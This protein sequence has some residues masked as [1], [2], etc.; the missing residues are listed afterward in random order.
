MKK[1]LLLFITLWCAMVSIAQTFDVEKNAALQIVSANRN[2]IGL[3]ADDLNNLMVTYSYVDKTIGVRYIYLQQTYQGIPVYNKTQAIAYKNDALASVMG[4][5][6]AN[7]ENKVNNPSGMPSKTAES[8]V[9]AALA[10]KGFS[11]SGSLV[12]ISTKEMGRKVEFG[13]LGVSKQNVTAQLMW[14]PSDNESSLKLGWFVYYIPTTTSD[15]WEIFIDAANSSIIGENNLT[16]SCNWDDPNHTHVFGEKHNEATMGSNPFDFSRVARIENG[17]TSPST[18]ANASYRVIPVPFEAPTFMPGAFPGASPGNSTV[19]NNPWTNVPGSFAN[20]VTLNWHSDAAASDYAYTRGNNVWAYQDRGNANAPS[21]AASASSTTALPALTFSA[22]GNAP[23]YTADPVTGGG[24]TGGVANNQLFNITNLFYFNN[25]LHDV[26]YTH[27]FDEVARN[28]QANNLGRGGNGNDYVFAEAQDGSGTNNANMSTP[29]D[30]GNGRMQMYLW[31]L[32][33]PQRDGDVDNGIIGHEFGHGVSERLM[34]SSTNQT[35]CANGNVGERQGEGI[36]DYIGLMFTQDWANSNVNSGLVGRGI[37]TFALNQPVTGVGIRTQRYSTDLAINNKKYLAVLPQTGSPHERGEHWCAAAWEATWA[38]IQ[39][40]GTISPTIY[41]NSAAGGNGNTG[42]IAAM[43]IAMQAMKLIPCGGGFIDH[44]NAWLKADTLLYGG[45]F[46]CSIWRAFQKRGMGF[47]ADQ[48]LA[49]SSTDQTP[50]ETAYSASNITTGVAT[51]PAGQNMTYTVTGSTCSGTA[52]AGYEMRSTLPA[53]V[54]FVSATNGGVLVGNI[55]KWPVSMAANGTFTAQVTITVNSNAF[56]GNVVTTNCLFESNL[57]AAR[58]FGCK[59]VTTPIT[60]IL[61]GCPTISTQPA[62]LTTCAG[63]SVNFSV[64]ANAVNTITYKWQLLVGATWTDLT[65]IAPYSNVGTATMTVNPT[66]VGL[67]GNQYRCLMTTSD[68]TGGIT[69]N[70]ATLTVVAASVGGAINPP[71]TTVCGPTSSTLMTLSGHVGNVVRWEVS[72]NGGGTWSTIAGTAGATTYTAINVTVTSQYRAVVQVSGGCAAVNSAIAVITS[73]SSLPL[74]IQADPATPIC[75]GDPARLTAGEGGFTTFSSATSITI[76]SSGAA[77]PYPSNLAVSGLPAGTTVKS[78]TLRGMNHTF[79]ADIDVVLRSPGGINVVLMSDIGG[80]GD[81]VNNTYTFDDAAT[82]S[83]DASTNPP[84]NGTYKPSNVGAT[85][86]MPAPFPG[87]TITQAAPALSLFNPGVLNGT[88]ELYVADDLGGD[89]GDISGGYQIV[90]AQPFTPVTTGTFLWTPATGLNS[91][92][93]NPVAASPNTTTTYTVTHN[94][95]V[96]CTRQASITV[97]VNQRPLV[98]TQPTSVV[99]CSGS[100]ATFSITATGTGPLTYQ[101]QVG[102]SATGPWTNIVAGAPYSGET[103]ATLTINPTSALLNNNWYRCTVGGL[104]APVAGSTSQPAK[105]SVN[106]LP[107]VAINPVGPVCGGIK[108]IVGTQLSVASAAPPVPGSQTFTSGI[109]NVLIPEGA[110]PTRP[111]TA[112]TNVIAVAGIPANATITSVAARLNA[113]HGFVNDIVAVLKAPTGAVIN[114]DAIGGYANNAGANYVNT[115]FSTAGVN[116]IAGGTAPFSNTYKM[117]AAG[118]TFSAFGFTLSGGPVG[119]DPTTTN[120]ALFASN[121]TGTTANGN[122]TLAAYDAGAPDV[123]NFTKWDLIINYTTPGTLPGTQ[124]W[125]Y[126]WAPTTGLYT[127]STASNQ[128]TGGNTQTVYAAPTA[129]TIYTVS[130][131]DTVTGCIGTS[132]VI[133]NYTP[134]AP[135]VTPNPVPMCLGDVP[136][137]VK[138]SS[139]T[140]TVANFT[141]NTISVAIPEGSFPGRPATAGT[142]A[143]AVSGIPA[144]ATITGVAVTLNATHAFVNDIVAV[145]KSPSGAV[146]NLDAIGGYQNNA[147]ANYLNTVFS[148][149]GTAS[150]STGTAP[151]TGTWKADL[152]GVTFSAFGFTLFGGPT[153]YDPTTTNWA[154]YMGS[155]SATP[156]GNWTIATYDVGAPDVGTLTKWDLKITYVVGVPATPAVWTPNGVGSGLY[157]NAAGTTPY[158]GTP[159]DS[160]WVRP[161]PAGTYNYDVTVQSLSPP[162][163]L[164]ATPMAGGNGNNTV[165]FNVTNNNGYAM[166]LTRISSNA[167][168]SGGI[169]AN[170]FFKVSAIAGNPGQISAANGWTL[171]G[172]SNQASTVTANTL[173]PVLTALT[174]ITIPAGATYGIALEFAGATVPAYTNGTGTV[175]TFSNNGCTISVDGN[176]GWGG[177]ATPGPMVNNPRNFNGT[178]TLVPSNAAPA[179]TSPARKLVVNVY[180]PVNIT[181]QPVPASVCTDKVTTFTATATGSS[182]GHN[183]QISA[184]ISGNAPWTNLVNNTIYSGVKT[185]TLTITNPPLSLNRFIYRDSVT[186]SSPCGPVLS[187]QAALT[188]NPLPTV[189]IFAT[190]HTKLFPGLS[191]VLVDTTSRPNSTYIWKKNGTVVNGSGNKI[192]VNVDGM[193]DYALTVTDGNGCTASSNIVTISDSANGKVFIYPNPNSGVFQVRY[194]APFN[195]RAPRGLNIYD[196]KGSRIAVE[197][198]P[199][200]AAYQRMDVDLRKHGKG[201]YWVEVID[202]NGE[203]LAVGRAVVL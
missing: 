17:T 55:V 147:G 105:L 112:A 54:T 13:K 83:M 119:F 138:S 84:A 76:P 52:I 12:P 42:N 145:L 87:G 35:G 49:T 75:A 150:I 41:Y 188:V 67:N 4:A 195:T 19:I 168:A 151:F 201:I 64:V 116:S 143:I 132:S 152:S 6:I 111:A 36:S 146:I 23:D 176:V 175:Q 88:W 131:R 157:S 32:S 193:G 156:N 38:I 197:Q 73:Q 126:T 108:D 140:T 120:P 7:I 31:T 162:S 66:A 166:D 173:N 61:A 44:R 94:N 37:G 129:L 133:V 144:G 98:A 109:I 190:P 142:N 148:S 48:G 27:G 179:C 81:L 22:F 24:T 68:C 158:T 43:R 11:P 10:K 181:L 77:N 203:R 164:P 29:G 127:N 8:A 178:V 26:L 198:Y 18:V 5:R 30:G 72:T 135:S 91:T 80:G 192:T 180:D 21:L 9:M 93:T 15:Y 134:P 196:A 172:G 200:N 154:T 185:P 2:A 128:Y 78:V 118:V 141:S 53:N 25:I 101:W 50:D 184:D 103:T 149:A 63:S 153:G 58:S 186:G 137:L 59:T 85:D 167:F 1:I 3:T 159:V 70:P 51:I 106:P 34:G 69:S 177:P 89:F 56:P 95:G 100:A 202:V 92:T 102:P 115:T 114:I 47:F 71:A 169:T 124:N 187:R 191:T 62:S 20:A 165:A 104:C 174:G 113:T 46:S 117:D 107:T 199:N 99:S 194:H 45:Q 40:A 79:V 121:L 110:F 82:V 139:S 170:A 96:G 57:P 16:V 39:Q 74:T 130:A 161:T 125:V 155:S 189:L 28:F 86:P 182:I 122:W 14:F 163:A 183:W 60:P 171:A 97:V 123:G 90:F 33:S 160:V 136:V 65:N